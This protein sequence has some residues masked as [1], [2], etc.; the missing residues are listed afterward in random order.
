MILYWPHSAVPHLKEG[1]RSLTEIKCLAEGYLCHVVKGLLACFVCRPAGCY[2]TQPV[3]ICT[4]SLCAWWQALSAPT[5]FI[6]GDTCTHQSNPGPHAIHTP[7]PILSIFLSHTVSAVS[8]QAH[9]LSAAWYGTD[10]EVTDTGYEERSD[11]IITLTDNIIIKNGSKKTAYEQVQM[12][13]N[14]RSSNVT[15]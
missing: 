12:F 5:H 10:K 2:T 7:Q 1:Q 9:R 4:V 8:V 11:D 14:G 6:P 3:C 13:L 15:W